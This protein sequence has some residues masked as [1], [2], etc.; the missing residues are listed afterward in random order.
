MDLG[1]DVARVARQASPLG[2]QAVAGFIPP[3]VE[4]C[5][6]GSGRFAVVV[7]PQSTQRESADLSSPIGRAALLHGSHV[8]GAPVALD[9]DV[10]LRPAGHSF[11]VVGFAGDVLGE[12]RVLW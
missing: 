1:R 4:S 2:R 9:V 11:E 7:G 6:V 10:V 3:G 8:G 12:R 5:L